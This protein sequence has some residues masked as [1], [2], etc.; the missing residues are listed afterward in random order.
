MLGERRHGELR[1]HAR[2]RRQARD[3]SEGRGRDR[4]VVGG[5]R[6]ACAARRL[7]DWH[8]RA[9]Q[10]AHARHSAVVRVRDQATHGDRGRHR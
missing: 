6:L 5:Q 10:R 1:R 2:R 3:R 7:R 8:H 4:G 9:I